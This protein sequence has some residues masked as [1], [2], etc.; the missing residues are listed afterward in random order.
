[1]A[2][3]ELTCEDN[4]NN[5]NNNNKI[6]NTISICDVRKMVDKLKEELVFMRKENSA[7]EIYVRLVSPF[8]VFHKM[9]TI[10]KLSRYCWNIGKKSCWN[11]IE[12]VNDYDLE[13]AGKIP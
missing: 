13:I 11:L 6:N 12:D 1:M 2:N 10:Y 5:N 3:E 9:T 8:S 7:M 4:N